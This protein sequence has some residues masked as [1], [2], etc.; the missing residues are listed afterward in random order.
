MSTRVNDI[1]DT[2]TTA[3]FLMIAS[4]AA[5]DTTKRKNQIVGWLEETKKIIQSDPQN[6]FDTAVISDAIEYAKIQADMRTHPFF[7]NE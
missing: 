5:T 4:L 1:E 3:A 7:R 6:S 2:V